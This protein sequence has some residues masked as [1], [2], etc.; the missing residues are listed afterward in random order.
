[1]ILKWRESDRIMIKK[2]V[3][4]YDFIVIFCLI[5][6]IYPIDSFYQR[7]KYIWLVYNIFR[8]YF[9]EI[10]DTC[11]IVC[12]YVGKMPNYYVFTKRLAEQV[13]EDYSKSLP[14]IICRPSISMSR[15][16]IYSNNIDIINSCGI[17]LAAWLLPNFFF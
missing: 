6:V 17:I 4:H 12:R 15:T 9:W 16:N 5:R 10:K 14:C 7:Y 1:M 13:I 11:I 3:V 8:I 2:W